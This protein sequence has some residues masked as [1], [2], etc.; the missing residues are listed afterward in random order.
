[1]IA[2]LDGGQVIPV[3]VG[4]RLLGNIISLDDCSSG[5][6]LGVFGTD[7]CFDLPG[8]RAE[9]CYGIYAGAR[10]EGIVLLTGC[11]EA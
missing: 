2:A 5:F 7:A 8:S 3:V 10:L 4:I 6:G 11:L 1:M 9:L